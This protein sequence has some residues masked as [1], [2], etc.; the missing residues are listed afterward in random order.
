ML[1]PI[2]EEFAEWLKD[3]H[4]GKDS[5]IKA[6]DMRQWGTP[7]EIR[8][9]VNQLRKE[10]VPICSGNV[11]YYYAKTSSEVKRVLK[12]LQGFL[13]EIEQARLGLSQAYVG[14]CTTEGI[15]P[16]D[17]VNQRTLF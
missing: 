2:R 15:E 12:F 16:S 14:L 6:K 10:G 3:Y 5:A 11:G 8:D 4:L 17:V 13:R 1:F 7:R 9:V